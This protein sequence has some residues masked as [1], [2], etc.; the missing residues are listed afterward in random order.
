[1]P[2]ISGS[3]QWAATLGAAVV[4]KLVWLLYELI[5]ALLVVS[6]KAQSANLD[7]RIA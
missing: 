4:M 3:P 2:N 5:L 1:M 6:S 7:L